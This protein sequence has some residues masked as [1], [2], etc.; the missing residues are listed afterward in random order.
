MT[1]F[2]TTFVMIQL[3]NLFNAKAFGSNHSAFNGLLKDNGLLLVLLIVIFGQW[4]IVTFGGKMFRTE[5]LSLTEWLVIVI[6]TSAVLWIG[7]L[8]R[9][10]KRIQ[11][12]RQ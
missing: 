6:A 12:K 9:W 3:W 10:I 5:P 7:E 1:V 2:F 8:W 11:I 4:L